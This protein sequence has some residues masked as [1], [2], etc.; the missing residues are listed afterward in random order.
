MRLVVSRPIVRLSSRRSYLRPVSRPCMTKRVAIPFPVGW[1]QTA[2]AVAGPPIEPPQRDSWWASA[3]LGGLVPPYHRRTL[4][5]RCATIRRCPSQPH[6]LLD[7]MNQRGVVV[8]L[9]EHLV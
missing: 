9:G 5:L 1:D 4:M 6:Q 3:R 2:L 7:F 8:G